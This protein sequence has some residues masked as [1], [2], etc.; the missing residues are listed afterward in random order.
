MRDNIHDVCRNGDAS[1]LETIIREGAFHLNE[2]DSYRKTP[3][4]WASQHGSQDC[5]RLLLSLPSLDCDKRD[6]R[7]GGTAAWWAAWGGH[8]ESL[9]LLI[10]GGW[11][12][13]NI[14]NSHEW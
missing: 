1:S 6:R 3:L 9:R 14:C 5:I 12:D 10:A 4:M 8:T 13:P 11:C 7:R 2:H